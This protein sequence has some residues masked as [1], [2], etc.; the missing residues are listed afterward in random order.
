MDT[1]DENS[2]EEEF[3]TDPDINMTE[4]DS[5]LNEDE[6]PSNLEQQVKSPS[7][8]DSLHEEIIL[9]SQSTA[10]LT[11]ITPSEE[12]VS[13]GDDLKANLGLGETSVSPS[14]IRNL[15]ITQAVSKSNSDKEFIR[16]VEYDNL[17]E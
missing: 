15:K 11:A 13:G 17:R 3:S 9:K 8:I 14:P 1:I 12:S 2:V 6:D 10:P 7:K 5:T 16:Y 4:E